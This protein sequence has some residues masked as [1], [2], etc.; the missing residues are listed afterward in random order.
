MI[1]HVGD[2]NKK[3]IG[4]I[5]H[6]Y[7]PCDVVITGDVVQTDND[8]SK[9]T[10][11][12]RPLVNSGFR[13]HITPDNNP[14]LFNEYIYSEL[15]DKPLSDFPRSSQTGDN[16]FIGLDGTSNKLGKGQRIKLAGLLQSL[17]KNLKKIVYM[18]RSPFSVNSLEGIHDSG[19]LMFILD[20]NIDCLL[21][22]QG[23]GDVWRD[24]AG[25][26]IMISSGKELNFYEIG[27]F[28]DY[29]YVKTV[30]VK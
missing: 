23:F 16:V 3:V 9:A 15:L 8:Y 29:N 7:K 1:L 13:L 24:K 17:N 30:R 12:L 4:F 14:R 25:I 21:F 27:M 26:D 2:I 5:K 20:G 18:Y 10:K 22:G 11:I 28:N 6:N 19:K